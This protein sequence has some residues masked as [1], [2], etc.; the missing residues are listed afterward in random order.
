MTETMRLGGSAR[1]INPRIRSF[2]A[3]SSSATAATSNAATERRT[4]SLD[5]DR[6]SFICGG[7][8]CA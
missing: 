2:S 8:R 3:A 5:P 7:R 1:L 4:A 6:T